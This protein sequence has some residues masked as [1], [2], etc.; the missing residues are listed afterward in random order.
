MAALPLPPPA[1]EQLPWAS[2]PSG[3]SP[4]SDSIGT[5]GVDG[6][7]TLSPD[8]GMRCRLIVRLL[9]WASAGKLTTTSEDAISAI[10]IDRSR[11]AFTPS[12]VHT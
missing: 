12:C 6:V 8:G 9:F 2:G 3:E 1:V 10:E 5:L 7:R 4:A 11:I